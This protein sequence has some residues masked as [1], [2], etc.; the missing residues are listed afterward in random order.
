MVR[1]MFDD[2]DEESL[3]IKEDVLTQC[4]K[5][6]TS[7]HNLTVQ[8]AK[9]CFTKAERMTSNCSGQLN[10]KKLSPRRMAAIKKAVYK[11]YPVRPAESEDEAWKEFRRA[12]DCSSRQLVSCRR[13]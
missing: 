1:E 12:I 5:K 9:R 3:N 7:K 6:A 11:V 8:L 10:K 2:Y 4:F 13:N